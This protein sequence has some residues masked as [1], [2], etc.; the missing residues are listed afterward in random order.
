MG[1]PILTLD[2][3]PVFDNY[4]R[5]L[6]EYN[7]HQDLSKPGSAFDK[8]DKEIKEQ[9]RK[10]IEEQKRKQQ[11]ILEEQEEYINLLAKLINTTSKGIF[12]IDRACGQFW[13]IP[14]AYRD[15][16]NPRN[17]R[18][19]E[20]FDQAIQALQTASADTQVWSGS[21]ADAY[22]AQLNVFF[23]Q[24]TLMKEHDSQFRSSIAKHADV[25]NWS[26]AANFGCMALLFG[27][28]KLVVWLIRINRL[29][30]AVVV[31]FV[32]IEIAVIAAIR[33]LSSFI[34][35]SSNRKSDAKAVADSYADVSLAARFSQGN[36]HN[37]VV[38]SALR[39]SGVLNG[40][41]LGMAQGLHKNNGY[42][43]NGVNKN[44]DNGP[45]D[46]SSSG[47]LRDKN[48][49]NT[50]ALTP[51][52]SAPLFA[53]TSVTAGGSGNSGI[54]G[55]SGVTSRVNRPSTGEGVAGESAADHALSEGGIPENSD[56][57]GAADSV[58]D[59]QDAVADSAAGYSVRVYA[60]MKVK[61]SQ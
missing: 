2:G 27:A 28:R 60:P 42:K 33:T 51:N 18:G 55:S 15:Y 32:A 23:E 56:I 17:P 26:H 45:A 58:A 36:T 61:E 43:N 57:S 5:Y 4:L 19:P 11:E 21:A 48:H 6:V 35:S 20:L 39:Q 8:L 34:T 1:S 30:A 10:Q 37:V 41:R 25:I 7:R 14:P 47:L 49:Q 31:T 13:P 29:I 52:N 38:R 54:S 53:N 22:M 40:F 59:Y 3:V 16:D 44:S 9:E 46:M 12:L 50:S 24:I